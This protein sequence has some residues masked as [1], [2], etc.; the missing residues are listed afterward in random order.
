F[1]GEYP[2]TTSFGC[3]LAEARRRD[4][5]EWWTEL[6]MGISTASSG[7]G[8]LR[9]G[10]LDSYPVSKP[11]GGV[12]VCLLSATGILWGGVNRFVYRA[13]TPLRPSLDAIPTSH[14]HYSEEHVCKG[15]RKGEWQTA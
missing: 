12:G 11:G 3:Q 5:Q 1:T 2:V 10:K 4:F 13:E 15:N 8:C 14:A 7:G 6:L 9:K